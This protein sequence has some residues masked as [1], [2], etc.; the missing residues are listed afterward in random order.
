MGV[1]RRLQKA[2]HRA[3]TRHVPAVRV[4]AADLRQAGFTSQYGQDRFVIERLRGRRGGV[5]VEVGAHDG[6]TFS[7]TW[8][9]EKLFGWTGLV[10]EPSPAAFARLQRTR[11]CTAVNGCIAAAPGRARFLEIEGCAAM[12][13]GVVDHYDARHLA[14]IDR[15]IAAGGGTRREVEVTCMT[16]AD[17]AAAHGLPRI[18]YLS[19]D[20][21]GSEAAVLAGIDF[22]RLDVDLITV[23][24]NY[25]TPRL[26]RLLA[27][28]G[29]RMIAKIAC[30]EVYQHERHLP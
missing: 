28:S 22:T 30:D 5:F 12:L 4:P 14:R 20:T 26:R 23:E 3:M 19:I 9:L 24:N 11:G 13:S 17:L 1:W 27:R 8:A 10:V 21:E 18:D 29:F 2:W 25:G 6:V 15:E 7:N 16:L